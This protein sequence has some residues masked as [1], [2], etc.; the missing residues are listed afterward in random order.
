MVISVFNKCYTVFGNKGYITSATHYMGDLQNALQLV[1]CTKH[2]T[3]WFVL[4]AII[5]RLV[6]VWSDATVVN[7]FEI[8]GIN[9]TF[10][11]RLLYNIRVNTI[12]IIIHS[13]KPNC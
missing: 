1:A 10:M 12:D 2:Y 5:G 9:T 11:A 6:P 3:Q 4:E 13:Y 7:K 8:A